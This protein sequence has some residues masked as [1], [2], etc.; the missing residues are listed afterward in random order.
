MPATLWAGIEFRLASRKASGTEGSGG[1][2]RDWP[3]AAHHLKLEHGVEI[4]Q[5]PLKAAFN[6]GLEVGGGGTRRRHRGGIRRPGP[7][8]KLPSRVLIFT[9]VAP[10]TASA[11][12]GASGARVFGAEAAVIHP[13]THGKALVSQVVVEGRQHFR[14]APSPL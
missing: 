14:G 1:P 2:V 9:V 5:N 6:N 11:G 3:A 13:R 7:E 12:P 8:L 4:W 10:A